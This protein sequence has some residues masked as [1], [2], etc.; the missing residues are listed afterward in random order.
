MVATFALAIAANTTI[1]SLLNAI[2]LRT[3]PLSDP[4]RLVAVSTTDAQTTQPGFIYAETFT[5]FR[6]QQRSFA[7][8]SMYTG[9][10]FPR[11]EAR[12]T[13]VYVGVEG[14]T[15]EYFAVVGA[16]LSA[17]R[18]LI[19]SD[20]TPAGA[21]APMVVI[22][23]RLWQRIFGGDSSVVGETLKIDGTPVTIVGVAAPGFYG[24]QAD[25]G[26]DVFVPLAAYGTVGGGPRGAAR[27][28]TVIARLAPGVTMAQARAEVLAR[29]PVI[30]TETTP[31]SLPLLEQSSV[32]SQRVAVDPI[33]SG[34]ST[35][36]RLYGSSLFVLIGCT[37]ILLSVAC[38]NLAGLLLARGLTR[39]HQ[40]AVRLVLGA[41]RRRLFQQS[42]LD[43]VLLA[44]CGLAVALPLA[45]W[46]SQVLT[47]ILSFGRAVPLRQALTPDARVL[48][49]A[50]GV[51]I[52]T[53]LL[54][55]TIPAVR[56]ATLPVDAA[57]RPSRA[58][59]RTLGRS[60]RLLLVAQIALSMVLVVGAGLFVGTLSRLHANVDNLRTRP[61]VWTRLSRTPG[62]RGALLGRAYF[63]ELIQQLAE[64]PGVD[65]VA[66]ASYFPAYLGFPGPLPTDS[67]A[68]IGGP[69]ASPVATGLTEFVSPRFFDTFGIARHRGRDFTWDDDG[70]A[71]PVAIVTE[72]VA[73]KC[74]PLGDAIGQHLRVSS[75]QVRTNVE[76]VG[77]VADA[78]IGRIR[79]PNV[80]VVFR[81]LMQ[82]LTR[83]QAPI[84]SV[85][86]SGDLTALREGYTRVVESRR[87]HVVRALYTL[88]EWIDFAVLQER[89]IAALSTSAALLAVFL[90]CIG[91]YGL[92][93]YAVASRVREIGV[94]LALGAKRID[95]VRMIVGDGL[96]VVVPGVLI[97]V[98]C[99]LAAATLV[100]SQLYGL[101]PNDPA[102]IILAASVFTATGFVAAL[103]P[104]LRAAKIDP[105]DAL[106]HE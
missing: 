91:L 10:W 104:A 57:L 94:R 96:I 72:S 92:L 66:L 36:R 85:R 22:T 9:G 80:A 73:R 23:D 78:P 19:D 48:T 5:A 14:V 62:D 69:E 63:Q 55:G 98:P 7:T 20:N 47:A 56:A 83:A 61:I 21:D 84:T 70:G 65:A 45:W 87:R 32:R 4:D 31:S 97:G 100:R 59:A 16:R 1:F 37:A 77:I 38:V 26:S 17:G 82:D 102:T 53:G 34:F 33:A 11:I 88:D 106:R 60:G 15:P 6:A 8:M 25:A 41:S 39:H 79:E 67:F 75:G 13:A 81:P 52:G 12:G 50:T 18:F 105:M 30:Q 2:V 74:F 86:V 103:L 35:L 99:A 24:L 64:I 54:V 76:I 40:F 27:A 58:V 3:L 44:L 68:P 71:P 93:A 49:I 95:V 46:S 89:L 90:A 28:R 42:L 101:A 51:A 29:W 43:G